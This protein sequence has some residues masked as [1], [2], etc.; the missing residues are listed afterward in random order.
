MKTNLFKTV[1]FAALTIALFARCTSD[2]DYEVLPVKEMIF[3]DDFTF[4]PDNDHTLTDRGYTLFNEAGTVSW[5]EE[6]YPAYPSTSGDA[7]AVFTSYQSNELSNIAWLITPSINLDQRDGEKLLFRAAQAYVGSSAN[8][9]EVLISTDYDGD[10]T[11]V[12]SSTW[13]P[14]SFTQPTLTYA[15][16]FDYVNS[17]VDLSSYTGNAHIAFRVKGSGT[18]TSLDGTYQIDNIRVI[19]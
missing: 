16:N 15:S 12:L 11:H 4:L 6:Q 17:S 10:P 9:L 18:N 5:S 13:T 8:S 3:S 19:Y 1:F 14:L 2:N 7:Y